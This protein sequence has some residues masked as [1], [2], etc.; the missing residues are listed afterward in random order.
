MKIERYKNIIFD[1][2]GVVVNYDL[3][4]DKRALNAAGLPTYSECCN[5]PELCAVMSSFLNGLT[6]LEVFLPQ[7]RPFC[8]PGV[9]DDVILRAMDDVIGDIPAER[10]QHI[11]ELRRTHRLLL[12]S[13]ICSYS[14]GGI[15]RK[16]KRLGY[17]PSDLFDDVFLSY[18]MQLAKPDPAIYEAVIRQSGIN[19]RETIFFDDTNKNLKA[20][21]PFGIDGTL[22]TM[23]RL[24]DCW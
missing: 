14:W 18:R 12:L 2:C 22:V 8:T 15:V 6:P 11:T 7:I 1:L 19:P 17:D 3:E 5:R 23:N 21:R 13:N 16:L 9:T 10:L 24:E 4:A 20:A